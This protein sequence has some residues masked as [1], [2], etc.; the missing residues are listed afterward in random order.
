MGGCGGTQMITGLNYCFYLSEWVGAPVVGWLGNH[1]IG[2]GRGHEARVPKWVKPRVPVAIP[3]PTPSK[4]PYPSWGSRV[5]C[6]YG[7]WYPRVCP[8]P[9]IP[10]GT[11]GKQGTRGHGGTHA[12]RSHVDTNANTLCIPI[13]VCTQAST[14]YLI[15]IIFL[16]RLQ[17]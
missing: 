8:Y 1:A 14:K 9:G 12:M 4:Y 10:A 5:Q 13:R 6:R 7:R 15:Y 2:A 3:A 16:K 17:I 11:E